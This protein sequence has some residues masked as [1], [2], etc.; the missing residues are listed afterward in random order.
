[1]TM[2]KGPVIVIEPEPPSKCELCGQQAECRPYG[3]NG[4]QI[5]V[6]CG[7]KNV[8]ATE[9]AMRRRFLEAWPNIR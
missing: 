3:P 4:E 2:V 9:A 1:M 5:C 8:A 7:R 6:D